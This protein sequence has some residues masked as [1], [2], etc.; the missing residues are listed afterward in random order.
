MFRL[1]F[2]LL[3]TLGGL[4]VKLLILIVV[5]NLLYDYLNGYTI[6][7]TSLF[8]LD[9]L[10]DKFVWNIKTIVP[11]LQDWAQEVK[12]MGEPIVRKAIAILKGLATTVQE[13]G[14]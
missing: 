4:L 2:W 8:S 10:P 6:D 7:R 1:L 12:E 3:H 13:A 9:A 11:L 5:T 14:V